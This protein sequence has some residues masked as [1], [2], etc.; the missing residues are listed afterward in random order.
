VYIAKYAGEN[1]Y[2][3]NGRGFLQYSELLNKI[4][5]GFKRLSLEELFLM[6]KEIKNV[7]LI[8]SIPTSFLDRID[9]IK[10]K[11]TQIGLIYSIYIINEIDEDKVMLST[12][13]SEIE[14]KYRMITKEKL[15]KLAR[16]KMAFE[17]EPFHIIKIEEER[18]FERSNVIKNL[19]N[20]MKDCID[21][22]NEEHS[23]YKI[24]SGENVY[25]EILEILKKFD[26]CNT[27]VKM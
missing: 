5:V 2:A 22:R 23:K 27:G 6:K 16:V 8:I 10:E 25:N 13:A 4:N 20:S 7:R 18:D 15:E 14:V 26:S 3:L 1:V 12:R 9:N 21:N 11:V 17:E 24:I 19:E